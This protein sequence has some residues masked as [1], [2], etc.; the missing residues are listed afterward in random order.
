MSNPK[1]HT[2]AAK[3]RFSEVQPTRSLIF[4]AIGAIAGLGIAGFGLFTA[5]GTA[6]HTVPPED[7]ALVNQQPILMV[8]YVAQLMS[9]YQVALADATR[10]QRAKV[11]DDMIREELFVQRGLE[12]DFPASDPDVRT[13]LVAAVEQQ[14][15]AD[16]AASE[17]TET[18]LK[19]YYE[20]HKD[21]Y[22][23]EGTMVVHDLVLTPDAGMTSQDA[24]KVA[25]A[26]ADSLRHATPVSDVAAKFK[27]ADSRKT[28]GEEFYFAVQ[29]HLG[30]TL[31]Q[32][33]KDLKDGQ[34]SEPIQTT[35]GV[36]ILVMEK[37]VAPVPLSFEKARQLLLTDF[38]QDKEARLQKQ[39]AQYLRDKADI[40]IAPEYK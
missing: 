5:K 10:E 28:N 1:S 23:S 17:P 3:G 33:A 4:L 39:D 30:D 15:A 37:N 26:A 9:T 35:D 25:G 11:L 24:L 13:A 19:A 7:V 34:V 20:Q 29:A 6:T 16:V 27:L 2:P 32:A 8:D 12:L 40:L 14:V 18:D 31:Y 36:H 38:R 22:A 21:K